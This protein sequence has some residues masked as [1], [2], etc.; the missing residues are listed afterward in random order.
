MAHQ[1][2]PRRVLIDNRL[3]WLFSDGTILPVFAGGDGTDEPPDDQL[4]EAGKKALEAERQ[5]A[6][7][8][9]KA[10]KAAE[11]ERDEFKDRL[12]KLEADSK[13]DTEKAIEA[14]RKEAA[15][16]AVKKER[17]RTNKLL[18]TAEVRAAAAGKVADKED[19]VRL[20]D[21][22]E[23]KVNEDGSIDQEAISKAIDKLVEAK[24][25]L[26]GGD[27]KK[28]NGSGDGGPR[29][30]PPSKDQPDLV[31]PSRIRAAYAES[32]KT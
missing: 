19:A 13:S 29:P 10:R 28:P 7:T 3:C 12:E 20:L 14:A 31:G 21:L 15:D 26:A 23:F 24:P 30:D 16:E 27:P 6:K 17:E 2:D 18:L 22:G 4:G 8:E 5:R 1:P 11:R 9:E 25:Y 32:A